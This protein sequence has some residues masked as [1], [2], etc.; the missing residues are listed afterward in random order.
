[1]N[2]LEKI[3]MDRIQIAINFAQEAIRVSQVKIKDKG[4]AIK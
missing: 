3:I 1:M 4:K 2:D